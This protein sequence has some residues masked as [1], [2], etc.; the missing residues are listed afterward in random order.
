MMKRFEKDKNGFTLS[1]VLI[2]LAI[3]GIVAAL[4]IPVLMANYQKVQEVAALKKAYSEITQALNLMTNNLGCPGDLE[5]TGIFKSTGDSL[6]NNNELGMELKK[7]FKLA[8]DC[9]TNYDPSDES[10]KCWS[11]SVSGTYD[12]ASERSDYS[13]YFG[14]AY[15]L[16]TADGFAI[17]AYNYGNDCTTNWSPSVP[18]DTLSKVCGNLYIDINGNKGPNNVGRDIF[19]L[20][21]TTGK[22]LLLYPRGGSK[23]SVFGS[24]SWSWVDGSGNQQSCNEGNDYSW[25][26]T[27][28]IM[29]QDWQ[30]LY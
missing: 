26:C 17:A 8:K 9:G 6:S 1:E 25:T 10:T 27:G 14:G 15:T 4:T 11:D 20:Y 22:G 2:T 30:M 24:S 12:G 19:V 18:N 28:R 16:L 7:Y 23:F 21:I 3:I 5:C 29:E 13:S